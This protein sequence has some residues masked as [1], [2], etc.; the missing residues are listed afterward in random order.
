M[1][2]E[3]ESDYL[4][5]DFFSINPKLMSDEKEA[6]LLS[7]NIIA[8]FYYNYDPVSK[9]TLTLKVGL[10]AREGVLYL[11]DSPVSSIKC[12][13]KESEGKYSIV[14]DDSSYQ[15]LDGTEIKGSI[16][17]NAVVSSTYFSSWMEVALSCLEKYGYATAG[18]ER[19]TWQ[20]LLA[21]KASNTK[22]AYR[23]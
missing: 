6:A 13:K 20:K 2:L 14:V 1:E 23:H 8:T 17:E 19:C 9:K 22:M 16:V 4:G 10:V 7:Q 12:L 11:G 21:E 18:E 15:A 3:K 5:N